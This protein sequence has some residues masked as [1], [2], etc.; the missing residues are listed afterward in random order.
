MADEII[1][2]SKRPASIKN[3]HK[4]KLTDKKNPIHNR[5]AKEF[6]YYYDILWKELDEHVS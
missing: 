5:K 6:S 1:V 4:I 3:I 2:L